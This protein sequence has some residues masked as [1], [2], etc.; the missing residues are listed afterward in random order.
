MSGDPA[1]GGT[2]H[3]SAPATMQD[4]AAAAGVSLKTVS[5]VVNGESGV[6]DATLSRVKSVVEQLGY[7]P[8]DLARNL[9]QGR[10]VG[11]VGLV[12]GDVGNPFYSG[13][14][15]GAEAALRRNG[16]LLV[17]ASSNEDGS[18]ERD[19]I[20]SLLARRVE[21][22][23]VVPTQTDHR[24]LVPEIRRG[25]QTVFVDRPP[26]GLVAPHVI[27]DN[28]GG[29]RRATEYLYRAGNRRIAVVTD[30]PELFTARERLEGYRS[31]VA[32]LGL[33]MDPELVVTG[34]GTTEAAAAAMRRLLQLSE[35]PDA[36]FTTNNRITTGALRVL[37]SAPRRV[38]LVGFD[39][40]E[41]ADLFGVSV[42][43]GSPELLGS[44]AVDVLFRGASG[45]RAED[46]LARVLPTRLLE[47]GSG[48][49]GPTRLADAR[50]L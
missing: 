24:W 3:D 4:V 37:L 5:R 27:F 34:C 39:D 47:R 46:D 8:N 20:E 50:P 11:A 36:V 1:P 41:L 10:D 42:V 29:A 14:A 48:A 18:I 22:L 15:S 43:A 38:G 44:R 30:A 12:I 21:Q 33:P 17:T 2:S 7:R 13:I 40:F 16:Q 26:Q 25:A 28:R 49:H 32:E 9:R 45:D 23:L 35:P 19:L 31:V 6:A